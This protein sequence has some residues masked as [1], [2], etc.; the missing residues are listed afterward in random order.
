MDV[1]KTIADVNKG[2]GKLNS[3]INDALRR[4]ENYTWSVS[5]PPIVAPLTLQA[6]TIGVY[7]YNVNWI[8]E[9]LNR[10]IG[11]GAYVVNRANFD[12]IG[13]RYSLPHFD[14]GGWFYNDAKKATTVDYIDYVGKYFGTSVL[15]APSYPDTLSKYSA[16]VITKDYNQLMTDSFIPN[17]N[18]FVDTRLGDVSA[19]IIAS[20]FAARR[21]EEADSLNYLFAISN[22]DSS[23]RSIS[24]PNYVN[25]RGGVSI[26]NNGV[27]N[28]SNNIIFGSMY[29]TNVGLIGKKNTN[30][31]EKDFPMNW[32]R[33]GFN[34]TSYQHRIFDDNGDVINVYAKSFI[35]DE[36]RQFT[37]PTNGTTIRYDYSKYGGPNKSV[38]HLHSYAE[39]EGENPH[40][41]THD[42]F[43]NG[44]RYGSV[45][46][47][48]NELSVNDI[49]AKTNKAFKKGTYDTL[50]ARFHT[51]N[52]SIDEND[53]TQ[54]SYIKEFG[55]SHGRN[56]R[57]V[58]P[59]D[60]NGYNN[61]YCR[62]WT[63]HHQYDRI[64]RLIRPF[65]DGDDDG[66]SHE[67][68]DKYVPTR[69][70]STP[71]EGGKMGARLDKYSVLQSNGYIKMTPYRDD[72]ENLKNSLKRCMFSIE[73][74][75][76]KGNME[77]LR[78]DQ[79]GP[80]GGRIMWFPP[81]NLK[82][83]ENV[84]VNWNPTQF[85]GR[86][87]NIYT[88][89]NTERN[90]NLSF[91]LLID[92]PSWLDNYVKADDKY[93]GENG[94]FGNVNVDS[95]EQRIL[96]FFAGC[97][98]ILP[99]IK[100]EPNKEKQEQKE[101]PPKPTETEDPIE[102]PKNTDIPDLI[103]FIYYP[104]NY[105]GRDDIGGKTN[106]DPMA[107]LLDG[108]GAQKAISKNATNIGKEVDIPI[109][110]SDVGNNKVGYE[111]RANE[112]LSK[113]FIESGITSS[114]LNSLVYDKDDDNYYVAQYNTVSKPIRRW[115]YRVD[116]RTSHEKLRGKEPS[117]KDS[118]SFQFNSTNYKEGAELLIKGSGGKENELE[119]LVSL[120]DFFEGVTTN[121]NLSNE[122]LTNSD[123]VDKVELIMGQRIEKITTRGFAN[124]HGT[125]ASNNK[126]SRDRGYVIEQWIR[127]NCKRL[128]NDVKFEALSDGQLE[129]TLQLGSDEQNR[130]L[131][132]AKHAK[133]YRSA[134]VRIF[135]KKE[136]NIN[137]TESESETVQ[138]GDITQQT[139]DGTL[140]TE[141]ENFSISNENKVPK[142]ENSD[143]IKDTKT[144]QVEIVAEKQTYDLT[145]T[146][147][148]A[149]FFEKIQG[150]IFHH[151]ITQ[152][153]RYFDPAFHS[154]TPEGFNARLTF[155]H[156]C[157]RQG[158][159][160]ANSDSTNNNKEVLMYSSANN[161][162]YGRSPVCI[163]RIGDFY[164]TRIIIENLSIDYS[165][166]D[167]IQ[168]DMNQE[169][170]GV[171]PMMAN[172]SI[173][174]KF[175]GGSD[176][177]GPI[178]RLQNALSHNYY[179]NTSVYD[180]KAEQVEYDEYGNINKFKAFQ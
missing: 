151:N 80:F 36:N 115:Y 179:A 54:S 42:S 111:T 75:A 92:H 165:V 44:I 4:F 121:K 170:I 107:Y 143:T 62:V 160:F 1:Y 173:S 102:I 138:G 150:T 76:W 177:S 14:R 137:A 104:N 19:P 3:Q 146:Y 22:I 10:N 85:I 82:F 120:A 55:L 71:I 106:I 18:N 155:L 157:T 57:K 129:D 58:S 12:E 164:Y 32:K 166:S 108:I 149:R 128:N 67:D 126:L 63:Y 46:S 31:G 154:I 113:G 52:D 77:H 30:I 96:R 50:V 20:T 56:L 45:K 94:D 125:V 95:N 51:P 168:W 119:N 99:D 88:Y 161:L 87:E 83:D 17:P 2:V 159:T 118:A 139:Q 78:V 29:S 127:K 152:K 38:K 9:V 140:T 81:Y 122:G 23:G 74:L 144:P 6:R 131:V 180:D 72:G 109:G 123:N 110:I 59:T 86:G 24:N 134:E 167:G 60:E 162:A 79:K 172:V 26:E 33:I 130:Y 117:Y 133:A 103:F 141:T 69:K 70:H 158:H 27:D 65:A 97:D 73:N 48:T 153:I 116:K 90:G 5:V 35:D 41:V 28:L 112:Y 61:P 98:H 176:L 7:G 132:S 171:M 66:L 135:L 47:Y 15:G 49:L 105:T 169:G 64:G 39:K 11:N 178:E 93:V 145:E 8:Q 40:N 101:N 114:T 124:S 53:V 136:E 89:T 25:L 147:N 91:T 34:G 156:Q 37:T 21:N 142:T 148:E 163:L 43:K 16:M 84:S 13:S 68:F 100:E 175:L 174:F